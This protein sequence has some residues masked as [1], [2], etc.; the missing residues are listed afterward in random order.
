MQQGSEGDKSMDNEYDDVQLTSE[1]I[2]KLLRD[3]N[4][5][6][7][8]KSTQLSNLKNGSISFNDFLELSQQ[9]G[10]ESL[11]RIKVLTLVSYVT[12]IDSKDSTYLIV[13]N[14]I[15]INARVNSLI[16]NEILRTK[17]ESILNGK[18]NTFLDLKPEAPFGWPW[19]GNIQDTIKELESM[20][21]NLDSQLVYYGYGEFEK[22]VQ[23]GLTSFNA[24][25]E[26]AVQDKYAQEDSSRYDFKNKENTPVD[27]EE[28]DSLLALLGVDED[29]D[30]NESEDVSEDVILNPY[31]DSSDDDKPD[32]DYFK[33]LLG[34]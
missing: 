26:Q 6:K 10:Y 25:R 4:D 3:R 28:D 18:R 34:G 22:D 21:E 17:V 32:N 2:E 1:I 31:L 19:F 13:D 14:G 8:I 27:D 7:K 15:P 9:N 30:E 16:K 33:K 20:G 23:T 12:G 5:A 29:E 24:S 11:K